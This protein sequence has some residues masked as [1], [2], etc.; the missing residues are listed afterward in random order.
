MNNNDIQH[1]NLTLILFLEPERKIL[2]SEKISDN[3][4]ESEIIAHPKFCFV[5]TMNPGGDY[6]KKEVCYVV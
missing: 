1:L 2:L 4:S 6:G 5:G 3:D